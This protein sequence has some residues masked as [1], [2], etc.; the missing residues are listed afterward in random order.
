M[1]PILHALAGAGLLLPVAMAAQSHDI[2]ARETV[3][4]RGNPILADGRYHSTDPAP[5]VDGDTLYILAGRDE[6]P[7]G[8]NDFVMNEWQLLATR[9]PA[10]GIWQH[11]PAIARP[12]A[13]FAWA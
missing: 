13:V 11:Y 5:L 4:V 8:V 7:D 12:E 9:D 2:P 1:K 10:A 3:R 6:A